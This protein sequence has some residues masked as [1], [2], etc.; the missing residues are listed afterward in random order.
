MHFL[1][2]RRTDL[3]IDELS[4]HALPYFAIDWQEVAAFLWIA[5]PRSESLHIQ[6]QQQWADVR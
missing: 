5:R 4:T 2:T 3:K 1:E 6:V